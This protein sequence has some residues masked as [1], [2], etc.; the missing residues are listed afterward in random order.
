MHEWRRYSPLTRYWQRQRSP[1][2]ADND[3]NAIHALLA[4]VWLGPA[5]RRHRYTINL[6]VLRVLSLLVNPFPLLH[7]LV[8]N[9]SLR[10]AAYIRGDTDRQKYIYTKCWKQLKKGLLKYAPFE[11]YSFI[12]ATILLPF[13]HSRSISVVQFLLCQIALNVAVIDLLQ[14]IRLRICLYIDKT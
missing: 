2:A 5:G 1:P 11:Q 12:F 13:P 7:V 9:L 6:H 14:L 8:T 3:R 4:T 10:N